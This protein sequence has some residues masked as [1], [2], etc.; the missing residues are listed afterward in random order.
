MTKPLL[1]CG[2][3]NKNPCLTVEAGP[4]CGYAERGKEEVS[5]ERQLELGNHFL[6]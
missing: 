5:S 2:G 1:N 3:M 6:P 4:L